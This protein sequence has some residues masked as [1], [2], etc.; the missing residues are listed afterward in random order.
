MSQQRKSTCPSHFMRERQITY[1]EALRSLAAPLGNLC[2]TSET[3]LKHN[4]FHCTPDTWT[5]GV[6]ACENQSGKAVRG[7]V[8]RDG[9]ANCSELDDRV[10]RMGKSANRFA[11]DLHESLRTPHFASPLCPSRPSSLHQCALRHCCVDLRGRARPR[12]ER[13]E[14]EDVY[15]RGVRG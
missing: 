13:W 10:A 3:I 5:W 4:A 15:M 14:G 7:E 8:R 9:G 1:L 6:P 2:P 11:A 12:S